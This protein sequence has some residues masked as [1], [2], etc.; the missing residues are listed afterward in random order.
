MGTDGY[1]RS[2]ANLM[3]KA[4][5]LHQEGMTAFIYTGNYAIP[6]PTLTGSVQG[7]CSPHG[8]V[9]PNH[10]SSMICSRCLWSSCR[11]YLFAAC[12]VVFLNR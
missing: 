10:G 3:Q 11:I 6:P 5:G 8:G 12:G 1:S 7:A 2:I 4:R 9:L